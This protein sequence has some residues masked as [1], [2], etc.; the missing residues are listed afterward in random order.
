MKYTE[1]TGDKSSLATLTVD[2]GS[3]K[4][5]T[6]IGCMQEDGKL[7]VYGTGSASSTGMKKGEFINIQKASHDLKIALNESIRMSGLNPTTANVSISGASVDS[8][9]S[10]GFIKIVNNEISE[11]DIDR[12]ISAAIYNAEI[13]TDCKIIHQFPFN[14]KIDGSTIVDNPIGMYAQKLSVEIYIVYTSFSNYL[15]I[16]KVLQKAG[17]VLGEI[18][19]STYASFI[20]NKHAIVDEHRATVLIDMGSD[21][22]SSIVVRNSSAEYTGFLGIGSSHITS[23][24]SSAL[25][26]SKPTAELIKKE[27]S[28]LYVEDAVGIIEVDSRGHESSIRR[29]DVSD[30][31]EIIFL[32]VE[33]T[34]HLLLENITNRFDIDDIGTIILTGGYA[35]IPGIRDLAQNIIPEIP[36]VISHPK[37]STVDEFGPE[38]SVVL[39]LLASSSAKVSC[40]SDERF[41]VPPAGSLIPNKVVDKSNDLSDLSLPNRESFIPTDVGIKDDPVDFN[42]LF[43]NLDSTEKVPLTLAESIKSFFNKLF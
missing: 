6:A 3:Y 16:E 24:I 39:G 23:D 13:P 27:H 12:A 9:T 26:V 4:V 40:S 19:L 30:V 2:F 21:S 7:K 5:A 29:Y 32:R 25:R 11:G 10:R 15:N 35:N 36:V 28:S 42:S 14:F 41:I 20:S 1:E 31:Q 33:E 17:L 38:M 18:S 37:S 43:K 22:C 34:L 8:T